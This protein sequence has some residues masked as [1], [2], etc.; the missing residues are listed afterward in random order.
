M[1]FRIL[2]P[3]EVAG[4]SGRPVS[5]PRGRPLALLALLLLHHGAVVPVDRIVDELWPGEAPA[6]PQ[7][8][9]QVVASRLRKALGDDV[10]VSQAGGYA[11]RLEDGALDADRFEELLRRGQSELAG[12]D[13]TA[14]VETLRRAL[15]IWRGPAL[16]DVRGE[17]FAQPEIAR[18][19]DMRLACISDRIDAD[20]ALGRAEEVVGELEALVAEH[21]LRERLRGQLMLALYRSGRQ[22]EALA[23]YRDARSVLV[24]ELGIEPSPELRELEQAILRQEA[25]A[26]ASATLPT[27]PE[28]SAPS[29]ELRRSVTCLCSALAGSAE[30]GE[31]TRSRGAAAAPRSLP[32]RDA[33]CLRATRRQR[34][35]APVGDSVVAVFGAP[36]AHEDDALRALRAA[37]EVRERLAGLS[38]ELEASFGVRPPARTG[39][40][41]GEV[42][43]RETPR[44][45]TLV[46]G[47]VAQSRASARAGGGAGRDPA[48]RGDAVARRRR[49][50]V[51]GAKPLATERKSCRP[52][53]YRLVELVDCR[54]GAGR[55]TRRSWAASA[56]SGYCAT[57][58]TGRSPRTPAS[59]SPCSASPGSG[60]RGWRGSSR[61]ARRGSD[62]SRRP[63]P[64][65]RRRRHVLADPR[66]R[67]AGDRGPRPRRA[68]RRSRGRPGCRA[69]RRGGAGPRGRIGGRRDPA[70][71]PPAVRVA[72][73][74]TSARARR[75]GRA[76]GRARPARPRRPPHGLDPGRARPHRLPRPAGAG[77]H[78]SRLGGRQAQHRLADA[79]PAL[80]R[81][82]P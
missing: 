56:S 31:Q 1:E 36:V 51:E 42:V 58:S 67:R 35:R 44:A 46:L 69:R 81:R 45:R 52:R 38:S 14:A 63:L 66:D 49:R 53:A 15:A 39:V 80:G 37:V 79:Q 47:E 5:V 10:L 77:G 4:A 60:S 73:P 70:G 13:S 78:P 74:G 29:R 76:V 25:G 22:A 75:R 50:R 57:R 30:L 64:V 68:R 72:R 7:N 28:P 9:V 41:T 65:V 59:S 32:R 12:D 48:R 71:V 6:H 21:P 33:G 8:A 54:A 18:L 26:P 27:A 61:P 16:A 17:L 3:V 2:G 20:V 40:S 82:E 24:D 34:P 43:V 62:R 11:L 55:R 23:A 19:E